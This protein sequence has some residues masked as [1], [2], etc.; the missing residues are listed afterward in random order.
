[1]TKAKIIPDVVAWSEVF[2]YCQE[3]YDK[4]RKKRAGRDNKKPQCI[5]IHLTEEEM[6]FLVRKME[7][8]GMQTSQEQIQRVIKDYS[9]PKVFLAVA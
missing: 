8:K 4:E 9:R 1:M 6:L 2:H 5:V 3:R 7:K